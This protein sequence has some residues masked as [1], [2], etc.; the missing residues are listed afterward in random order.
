MPLPNGQTDEELAL[1]AAVEEVGEV[2]PPR[3]K[4]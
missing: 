2:K 1:G 4:D 3:I